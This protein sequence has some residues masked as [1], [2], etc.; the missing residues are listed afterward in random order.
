MW[1][2][3]LDVDVLVHGATHQYG[4]FEKEGKFFVNPGSI[5]G[6][7]SFLN[8]CAQGW[9]HAAMHGVLN[10]ATRGPIRVFPRRQGVKHMSGLPFLDVPYLRNGF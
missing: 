6:A 3:K 4:T 1:Q 7:F 8:G 10:C 5:T 9:V 2:R